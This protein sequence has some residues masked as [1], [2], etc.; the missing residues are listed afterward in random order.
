MNRV[1][2]FVLLTLGAVT[3][4]ALSGDEAQAFGHRRHGCSAA[5]EHASCAGHRGGVLRGLL[6]VERRQ[7]RRA[8]RR[9]RR[10]ARWAVHSCSGEVSTC[11]G[12]AASCS[13]GAAPVEA[14]EVYHVAPEPT[15][16]ECPSGVCP[17]PL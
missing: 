4:V 12:E 14:V 3:G 16:I 1:V 17:R 6:G 9:H 2:L 7:A 15:L 5:A 13:G 10:A 8:A 11:G